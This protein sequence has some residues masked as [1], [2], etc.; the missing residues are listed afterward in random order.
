MYSTDFSACK[1]K[2]IVFEYEFEEYNCAYG[3]GETFLLTTDVFV[4]LF[5]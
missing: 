1:F 4:D 3:D 5:R 2:V